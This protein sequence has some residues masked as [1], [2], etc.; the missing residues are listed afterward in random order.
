MKTLKYVETAS[1]F[2]A[3]LLA[4]GLTPIAG[5]ADINVVNHSFEDISGES[6][7]GEFTFGALNGWDVYE[8]S[9]GQT[10]NGDG[11]D[12]YA[13]TLTPD[14]DGGGPDYVFIT[15]GAP[16]GDRVGIA[17]NEASTGNGGEYGMVQTITTDQLQAFT[18]YTLTV[19]VINI[20]SGTAQSNTFFNLEG[21]P[22]YRIDLLAGGVVLASDNN[23]LAGSIPEGGVMT[24][25]FDFATGADHDQLGEDL[26]IRL[27]NLNEVDTT[28]ATTTAADLEVDFDNVRLS[29]VAVP[30]PA[31]AALLAAGV[32]LLGRRRR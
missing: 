24:S 16:D 9:V 2:A 7:T 23:T 5:A 17:F 6:P 20:A 1:V 19:E 27:V 14:L 8:S 12:Y 13:G 21:F 4:L 31:S 30:E 11:P 29:A 22:G 28:D 3:G 15:D 32:L 26:G 18:T 10:S 25:S